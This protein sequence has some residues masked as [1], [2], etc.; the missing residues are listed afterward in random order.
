MGTRSTAFDV[1]VA[2]R[3]ANR[4]D[5]FARYWSSTIGGE[6]VG[7]PWHRRSIEVSQAFQPDILRQQE[8][9]QAGKPDLRARVGR[10]TDMERNG[11]RLESL[12]YKARRLCVAV[13]GR[14][15]TIRF[16]S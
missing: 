11:V 16:C 2:N 13:D 3:K 8:R 10:S 12:T 6:A 7:F 15:A 9:R 14:S 1:A 5:T 4:K